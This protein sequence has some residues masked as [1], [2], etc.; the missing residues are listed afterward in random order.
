MA[1]SGRHSPS[2]D[3]IAASTTM[4][5]IV[6]KNVARSELIPATPT[7]AKIAVSAANTAD[8]AAQN[9][10]PLIS[11]RMKAP[12]GYFRPAKQVKIPVTRLGKQP[13]PQG[14]SSASA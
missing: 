1:V 4:M 8:I 14:R 7:L 6:R 3:S 11:I 2:S 13:T 10:Q 5:T 9:G 12:R